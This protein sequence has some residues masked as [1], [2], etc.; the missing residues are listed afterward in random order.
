MRFRQRSGLHV[1]V[2]RTE[3]NRL[4]GRQLLALA[5][6]AGAYYGLAI[7]QTAGAL[8]TAFCDRRGRAA[9]R[10]VDVNG[11][12][13]GCKGKVPFRGSRRMPVS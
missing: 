7:A 6:S 11:T 9:A 10:L 2:R 3:M 4:D 1:F 13:L 12:K 8:Q 5:G